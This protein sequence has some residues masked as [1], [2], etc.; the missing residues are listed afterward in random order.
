M[1]VK[2]TGRFVLTQNCASQR[3]AVLVKV[4]KN[5]RQ[6]KSKFLF[7]FCAL[8]FSTISKLFFFYRNEEDA[9][10]KQGDEENEE[11]NPSEAARSSSV[12]SKENNEQECP[13]SSGNLSKAL[14]Y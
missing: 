13:S 7:V 12:T 8:L 10:S 3:I 2:I 1:G 6:L 11:E 4:L 5:P 9:N 14:V